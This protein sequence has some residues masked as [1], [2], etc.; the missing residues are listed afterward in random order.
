MPAG[1]A[2][3]PGTALIP[4]PA[5][6]R[7]AAAFRIPP[8]RSNRAD[9]ARVRGAEPWSRD[10]APLRGGRLER[11]RR[12]AESGIAL[13]V[14]RRRARR[15]HRRRR[16]VEGHRRRAGLRRDADAFRGHRPRRRGDQPDGRHAQVGRREVAESE[17]ADFAPYLDELLPATVNVLRIGSRLLKQQGHGTYVQITGGS[18]RRGRPGIGA[19][20][21]TAFAGRGFSRRRPASCA[22]TASTRP[23]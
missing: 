21:A 18:A 4:R 14:G 8:L 23:C 16:R 20:A 3:N 2:V 15:P 11:R 7:F 22:S 10:R 1:G 12:G 9:A 19:W 6:D 13:P 5:R 17:P